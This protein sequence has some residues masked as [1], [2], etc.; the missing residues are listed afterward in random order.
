[1]STKTHD[2]ETLQ[3][4]RDKSP[5]EL[6]E[7]ATEFAK[8]GKK[9][10]AISI[11]SYASDM[12][13]ISRYYKDVD[14]YKVNSYKC[15]YRLYTEEHLGGVQYMILFLSNMVNDKE[16]KDDIRA[17][18]YATLY[19]LY[20]SWI[21]EGGKI[22]RDF[23][24]FLETNK[25]MRKAGLLD[26]DNKETEKFRTIVERIKAHFIAYLRSEDEETT[27]I[28]IKLCESDSDF[29]EYDVP[30][31]EDV[32]NIDYCDLESEVGKGM[33]S[34]HHQN[35]LHRKSHVF[36]REARRILTGSDDCYTF[37]KTE[38]FEKYM[39]KVEIQNQSFTRLSLV[40]DLITLCLR[41]HQI[42]IFADKQEA[43]TELD[44]IYG[45]HK[46]GRYCTRYIHFSEY[47]FEIVLEV[48][49]YAIESSPTMRD[50][51]KKLCG[52]LARDFTDIIHDIV[53]G[54]FDY[55]LLPPRN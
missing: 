4:I 11:L 7:I 54:Q 2:D 12:R 9:G 53:K 52:M 14:Y 48:I 38:L 44:A 10:E 8:Q 47:E 36:A 43:L 20:G 22:P 42:A 55:L 35:Y 32:H 19:K 17:K 31:Y 16:S 23:Y 24:G 25:R 29:E 50:A 49:R 33:L 28:W 6:L 21:F 40:F 27:N 30:D 3:M 51:W 13:H 34:P 26:D 5:I 41:F 1:M 46:S 45:R 39:K 18:P 15:L 37:S